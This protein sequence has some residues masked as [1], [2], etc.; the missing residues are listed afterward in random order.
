MKYYIIAGEKSGDLHASNLVKELSRLDPEATFRGWGGDE[1]EKAGVDLVTHYREMAFMGFWE[2][3]VNF[4]TIRKFI[5]QCQKDI[6]DY[7]PDVVILVDY[8]GFNLRIAKFTHK[9]GI[10][11]YY[12][13]SPKLWAWNQKRAWKIKRYID[14]MFVILHFEK[15][16]YKKFR[17]EVDYVGNPLFDAISQFKA[18]SRFLEKHQ[19]TEKPLIAVLPGSRKQELKFIFETMLQV[20]DDFPGYQ[21]VVAGVDNLPEEM[22]Q[23]ALDK[24]LKVVYNAT[25]DLLANAQAAVVT[26]G[27]ATLET[28]LFKVPEVVCY[29]MNRLTYFIGRLVIKVKYIS[30]VNLLAQKEVVKELIQKEFTPENLGK[31]LDAALNGKREVIMEDYQQLIDLIKTEGTSQRTAS[32]MIN[33]L[34]EQNR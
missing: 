5:K 30:L 16:F 21:F 13:I 15:D 4:R 8:A 27:T 2:V 31:E 34:K 14:R 17:M 32:L 12:Y 6:L 18:D 19:L 3:I 1:M 29:K 33:Y 28:A 11:N 7:R 26:S 25:Y 20:V 10:R 23:P 9:H 24:G 22:Y